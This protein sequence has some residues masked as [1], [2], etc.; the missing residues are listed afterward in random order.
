MDQVESSI[1][2]QR[3]KKFAEQLWWSLA[4]RI[5]RMAGELYKWDDKEWQEF[6]D[7]FLRPNDYSVVLKP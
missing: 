5:V 6:Q 7:L 2:I 3:G 1:R 4:K